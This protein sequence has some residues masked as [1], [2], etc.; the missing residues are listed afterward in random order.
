MRFVSLAILVSNTCILGCLD[1]QVEKA[2]LERNLDKE[3]AGI[4]GYDSFRQEAYKL[5]F[6]ADDNFNN[7]QVNKC[8]DYNECE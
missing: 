5:A 2:L 7:K 3:Y 6:G 8:L 4:M 1:N